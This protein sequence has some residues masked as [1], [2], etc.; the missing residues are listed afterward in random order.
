MVFEK[1]SKGEYQ[2]HYDTYSQRQRCVCLLDFV[3]S[4]HY[5]THVSLKV[6]K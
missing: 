4:L 3:D 2:T 6:F 1:S 5:P